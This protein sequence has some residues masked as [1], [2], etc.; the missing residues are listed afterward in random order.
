MKNVSYRS[1]EINDFD[2]D[3]LWPLWNLWKKASKKTLG[4][5]WCLQVF[6]TTKLLA[7]VYTNTCWLYEAL[8]QQN[9]HEAATCVTLG[10][11]QLCSNPR[12]S[13]IHTYLYNVGFNFFLWNSHSY[14][15]CSSWTLETLLQYSQHAAVICVKL[16]SKTHGCCTINAAY[17][18]VKLCCNTTF[19][20]LLSFQLVGDL[21]LCHKTTGYCLCSCW[22]YETLLQ[23]SW[24][25]FMQLLVIW[26]SATIFPA[27]L[28][29]M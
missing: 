7:A 2:F 19:Y 18:Y 17:G 16:Y 6:A 25:L 8:T 26:N 3:L 27:T 15:Q 20:W 24:V 28:L 4:A 29:S 9:F 23:Y 5:I 11:E 10:Y 22:Q 12:S 21:K 14:C 1:R 13:C